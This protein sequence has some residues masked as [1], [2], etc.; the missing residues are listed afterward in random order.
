MET[1]TLK[2]VVGLGNPGPEYTRTRHNIGFLT[3]DELATDFRF[4]KKF[5]AEISTGPG[6]IYLKP[7]TFMN[8]SGEAVRACADYYKISP[9]HIIVVYDDKD[10]SFGT[11]RLRSGGSSAGHNGVQSIINH[12]GTPDFP[13]IRIDIQQPDQRMHGTAADFVLSRFSKEE[14]LVLNDITA[15]AAGAIAYVIDNGMT[16]TQHNDLHVAL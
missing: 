1:E 9:E 15:E 6:Y 14:E 4:E 12:L 13:R 3:L 16:P 5:K 8:L 7:M 11:I 2:M 10:I